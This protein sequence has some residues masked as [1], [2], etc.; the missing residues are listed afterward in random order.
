MWMTFSNVVTENEK[1]NKNK[2]NTPINQTYGF[3]S[4]RAWMQTTGQYF[5]IL[6]KIFNLSSLVAFAKIVVITWKLITVKYIG[7]KREKK[8]KKKKKRREFYK[9]S[10]K[11]SEFWLK[12]LSLVNYQKVIFRPFF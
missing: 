3:L 4:T 7:P 11:S 8:K 6:S 2:N 12:T 10:G 5:S 9:E 1:K